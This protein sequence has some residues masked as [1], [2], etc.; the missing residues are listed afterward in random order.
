MVAKFDDAKEF[1]LGGDKYFLIRL[2]RKCN[3]IEVG[4]CRGKNN[5]LLKIVGKK[6]L[7]IYQTILNKERVDI[8][9]DHAAFQ[10]ITKSLLQKN[11]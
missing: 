2:N 6:P 3:N 4:F 8:N 9:K 11:L 10:I 5:L 7:E 1:V